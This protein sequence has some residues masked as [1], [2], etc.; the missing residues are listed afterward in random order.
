MRHF[1]IEPNSNG[2]RLKGCSNEPTFTSLAALIFQHTVTPLAL[3]IKLAL[4]DSDCAPWYNDD[5]YAKYERQRTLSVGAPPAGKLDND[6]NVNETVQMAQ[7]ARTQQSAPARNSHNS[8]QS[9]LLS[10][11]PNLDTLLQQTSVNNI[12]AQSSVSLVVSLK[13]FCFRKVLVVAFRFASGSRS[14][15][16]VE[17]S[18]VV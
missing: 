14:V 16:R 8:N 9:G 10:A 18:K 5:G 7:S 6:L 4:P 13:F 1:L 15:T 2:I 3:P 12:S 17:R 11:A